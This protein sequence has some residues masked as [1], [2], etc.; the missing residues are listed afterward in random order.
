MKHF[1]SSFGF[2][3]EIVGFAMYETYAGYTRNAKPA[4]MQSKACY[5]RYGFNIVLQIKQ[6]LLTWDAMRSC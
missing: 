5:Q 1:K 2:F 4:C 3:K 6:I